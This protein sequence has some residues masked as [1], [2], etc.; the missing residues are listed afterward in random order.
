MLPSL[1]FLQVQVFLALRQLLLHSFLHPT[2]LV[3]LDAQIVE[4]ECMPCQYLSRVLQWDLRQVALQQL[5][6][7]YFPV[8]FI[9]R[10]TQARLPQTLAVNCRHSR[11]MNQLAVRTELTPKVPVLEHRQGRVKADVTF[12]Y[13]IHTKKHG[14]NGQEVNA[15]QTVT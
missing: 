10:V 14:V 1:L 6:V 9:R 8:I 5:Q 15:G 12:S 4:F 3:H 2:K 13:A 7:P 11:A